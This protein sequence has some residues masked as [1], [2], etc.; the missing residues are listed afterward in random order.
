MKTPKYLFIPKM[1][2]Q[3]IPIQKS[4]LLFFRNGQIL[5]LS[6]IS[7]IHLL[8]STSIVEKRLTFSVIGSLF[9]LKHNFISPT[10]DPRKYNL[11]QSSKSPW[12]F[13]SNNYPILAVF[14]VCMLLSGASQP[15][16]ILPY[17]SF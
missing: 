17:S 11:M 16:H 8:Y 5:G 13:L 15:R 6:A 3:E 10:D 14:I 9:M 4:F 7:N 2:E 12:T 1:S